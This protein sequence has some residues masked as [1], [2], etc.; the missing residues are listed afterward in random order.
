MASFTLIE[1]GSSKY[2][3]TSKVRPLYIAPLVAFTSVVP[4]ITAKHKNAL[5]AA[6]AV[7]LP[8]SWDIRKN[9]VF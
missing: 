5:Q 2:G 6:A 1:K 3:D 7:Q 8:V 4:K 9:G